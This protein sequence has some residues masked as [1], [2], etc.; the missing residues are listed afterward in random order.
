MLLKKNRYWNIRVDIGML[1]KGRMLL[2]NSKLAFLR[3][4][5]S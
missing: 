5:L 1:L 2:K 3:L 4:E